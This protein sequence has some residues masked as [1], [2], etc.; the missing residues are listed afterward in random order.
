MQERPYSHLLTLVEK[1]SALPNAGNV[2]VALGRTCYEVILAVPAATGAGALQFSLTGTADANSPDLDGGNSPLRV[3]VPQGCT[4]VS[5]YA[6]GNLS[7]SK[8]TILAW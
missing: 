4:S 3:P 8:G 7:A 1:K 2:T 6:A 5:F